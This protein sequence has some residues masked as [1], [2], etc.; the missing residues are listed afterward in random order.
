MTNI[1]D[2]TDL[3]KTGFETSLMGSTELIGFAILMLYAYICFR[4]HMSLDG[5]VV[6]MAPMIVLLAF[7]GFL[8]WILG[9]FAIVILGVIAAMGFYKL[10]SG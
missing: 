6:V 8:P 9:Y 10:V 7:G 4:V 5:V 3:F 1:T 2:V